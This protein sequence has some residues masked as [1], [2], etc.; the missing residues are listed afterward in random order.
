[1]KAAIVPLSTTTKYGR[2]DANFYVGD[3]APTEEALARAEAALEQKKK[4]VK[5]LKKELRD[6]VRFQNKMVQDGEVVPI[7]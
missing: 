2:W 3:F 4:R 1:V 6:G 5:E 7:E